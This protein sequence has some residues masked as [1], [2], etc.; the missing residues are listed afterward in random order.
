MESS[1]KLEELDESHLSKA[2][3]TTKEVSYAVL[4]VSQKNTTGVLEKFAITINIQLTLQPGQ[5]QTP[6]I[7]RGNICQY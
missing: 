6:D 1:E 3:D 2:R 5:L 7:F 4:D